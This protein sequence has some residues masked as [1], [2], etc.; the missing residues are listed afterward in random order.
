M[1]AKNKK[2]K[3]RKAPLYVLLFSLAIW[4]LGVASG[5]P[6]MVLQQA[7]QICLSCIGIG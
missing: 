5:E 2:D 3:L 7:V 6:N 4:M 1:S